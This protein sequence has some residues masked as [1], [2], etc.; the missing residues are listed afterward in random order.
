MSKREVPESFESETL[1]Q[2]TPVHTGALA[3]GGHGYDERMT[4]HLDA[5][6]RE[7]APAAPPTSPP[8]R[9]APHWHSRWRF[10][11]R[12]PPMPNVPDWATSSRRQRNHLRHLRWDHSLAMRSLEF[13]CSPCFEWP[14]SGSVPLIGAWRRLFGDPL[15][16][17]EPP[18]SEDVWVSFGSRDA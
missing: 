10:S 2:D 1:P 9:D 17:R 6:R 15:D 5:G 14:S 11:P 18:T 8:A 4:S 13:F 7:T 12:W 3:S 16:K